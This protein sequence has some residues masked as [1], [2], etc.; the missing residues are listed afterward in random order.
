MSLL[1]GKRTSEKKPLLEWSKTFMFNRGK[2]ANLNI[3]QLIKV[4]ILDQKI[5]RVRISTP[6]VVL[7]KENK[8]M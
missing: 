2:T 1:A 8:N 7:K 4:P 3:A 6:H 5:V